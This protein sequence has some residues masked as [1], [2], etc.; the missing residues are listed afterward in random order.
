MKKNLCLLVMLLSFTAC[1]ET[2]D[3]IIK[4]TPSDLNYQEYCVS[5]ENFNFDA[6]KSESDTLRMEVTPTLIGGVKSMLKADLIETVGT[7][8]KNS[9]IKTVWQPD[10]GEQLVPNVFTGTNFSQM[11]IS[12]CYKVSVTVTLPNPNMMVRGFEGEWTGYSGS[13]LSNDQLRHQYM[14]ASGNDFTFNTF[15]WHIITDINGRNYGLTKCYVPFYNQN[16]AKIYYR[17]YQ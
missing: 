1:N 11:T 8:T 13:N 16:K 10:T 15:V 17:I 12:D 14:I 6:L 5:F 7:I 4:E 2:T 3:E 9:G